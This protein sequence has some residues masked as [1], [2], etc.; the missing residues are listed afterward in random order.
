M[1]VAMENITLS[2]EAKMFVKKLFRLILVLSLALIPLVPWVHALADSAHVTKGDIEAALHS[3]ET[4]SRAV[5][6]TSNSMR[7]ASIDGFQ[8]GRI[9]PNSDG[10]H[11]CVEDWHLVQVA[12]AAGG[13]KSY[14]YQS[15][16]ADLSGITNTFRLD[17]T[18]LPITQ[19]PITR[20]V[21]SS[22]FENE[23]GYAVGSF[24]SPSDLSIGAH[25]LTF[26]T[27]FPDES[28]EVDIT[29]YIDAPGTGVCVQ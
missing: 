29:F 26:I 12:W 19:T 3:W 23:Y 8:R 4:G 15:A 20:R 28:F 25:M 24:L 1:D 11:Y 10:R 6:F 14:T 22:F 27:T 9:A 21:V 2:Q 7:A 5:F 17:D 18:T 13:D 16:L